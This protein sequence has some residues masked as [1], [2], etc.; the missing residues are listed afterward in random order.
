LNNSL[1]NICLEYTENFE[2]FSYQNGYYCVLVHKRYFEDLKRKMET[3]GCFL[4]QVK[5]NTF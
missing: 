3:K 2:D 1:K 4:E 5:K